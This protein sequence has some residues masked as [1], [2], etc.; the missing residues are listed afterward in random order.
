[1]FPHEIFTFIQARG[2]FGGLFVAMF[3]TNERLMVVMA[4]RCMRSQVRYA[5]RIFNFVFV[6]VACLMS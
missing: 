6:L 1:M 3:V 4:V 5:C 2:S